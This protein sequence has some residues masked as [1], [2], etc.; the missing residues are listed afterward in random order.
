MTRSIRGIIKEYLRRIN[1]DDSHYSAHSLR[2]SFATNL[3]KNGGS[4]EEAQLILRHKELST[5]MIYNHALDRENSDGE[6][7]I[8]D[9]LFKKGKK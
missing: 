9:M 6:L 7:V 4:L 1:I 5:T 2:H 8:S 3:I